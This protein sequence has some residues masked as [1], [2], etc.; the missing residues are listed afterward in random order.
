M[1]R[2][3]R[4]A[5][6]ATLATALLAVAF[7]PS[8]K[9]GS[10]GQDSLWE[11]VDAVQQTGTVGVLAEV[12]GPRGSAYAASGQADTATGAL[13]RAVDEFRIG[14][15]TK[16]FVAT[17]VLQLAAERRLSLDDTVAHW[18]PGVVSGNGNDGSK[19][20]IRELL[21]HTSGLYN[22]AN[23]FPELASSAA[24]EADRYTTYTPGQLV[25]IAMRHKPDFAPGTNWEYSDT[26]YILA[27]MIIEKATGHTWQQEV[28]DRIIRP[29]GLQHT[30]APA[31]NPSI[32]GTHLHGYS[33][34]GS[35]PA[36]DVTSANM[37][38]AGSSGAM[39]S[40]TADLIRFHQALLGG[41]LL[42]AAELAEMETTVPAH[43]FDSLWPGARYGLGLMWLP[44]S[45]GGG[46]YSH[47]GDVPG[48]TTLDGITPDGRHAAVVEATGD[49]GTAS[50]AT[51]HAMVAL[52]DQQMCS[53]EP[54][55]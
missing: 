33:D 12:I 37:T 8:A 18:L 38:Y 39:I 45:C 5:V 13:V 50:L 4:A 51:Q 25:A 3:L 10:V 48:Y 19:I 31:T 1:I 16:T 6:T 36:I 49:G 15:A 20:T 28:S 34:F 54:K 9:A 46:I 29:L 21:Q 32:P 14:S 11:Q 52:V 17:V 2:T 7:I 23:D 53:A 22:Y 24:F 27:G 55:E 40:T 30:V 43:E 44:L 35:G 47:G 26:N 41:R 42:P